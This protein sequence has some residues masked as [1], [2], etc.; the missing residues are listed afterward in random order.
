MR[1]REVW[2]SEGE[3]VWTSEGEEVWISEGEGGVD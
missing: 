2:T 1:V 3:R